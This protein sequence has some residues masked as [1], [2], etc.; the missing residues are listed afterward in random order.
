MK[1]CPQCHASLA[2]D[3]AFCTN[4]GTPLNAAPQPEQNIQPYQQPVQQQTPP[5]APAAPAVSPYDHTDEFS[6]EEV[7]DNK[8]FALAIYALSFIGIIIA[9]LAKSSDNSAYLRFH[10]KQML[11]ILITEILVGVAA[12]VLSWTCIGL[13]A[14]CGLL[15]FLGVVEIICFINVCRNK[16]I[17]PLLVR[18]LTFLK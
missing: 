15:A 11:M 4:C 10:I 12:A 14:G 13:I 3:A 2:D 18:K 9:L 7:H 8:I 16:S 1:T 6:E 5:A 17:E